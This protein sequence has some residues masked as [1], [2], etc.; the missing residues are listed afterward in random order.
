MKHR[1]LQK[2]GSF[3]NKRPYYIDF[4][5]FTKVCGQL[6]F[7]IVDII[8]KVIHFISII[9]FQLKITEMFLLKK[10]WNVIKLK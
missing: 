10:G 1:K 5:K 4:E 6:H 7:P 2:T 9:L 3:Y 8:E